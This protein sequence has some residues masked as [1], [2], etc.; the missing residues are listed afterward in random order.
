MSRLEW[1][2]DA[3]CREVGTE[4]FFP[5]KGTTAEEARS[6]CRA[7]PVRYEC[8]SHALHL[9]AN[10]VWQVTGIWGGLTPRE[11]RAL[12]NVA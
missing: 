12:R 2:D 6:I 8:L 10:G 5:D 1:L 11:R 7:C 4:I 9:E 3:L